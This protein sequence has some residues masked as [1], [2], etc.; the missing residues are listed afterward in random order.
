MGTATGIQERS[1]AQQCSSWRQQ[2]PSHR[3]GS[4]HGA[5]VYRL[6]KQQ[7]AVS[8]MDTQEAHS[9]EHELGQVNEVA[10]VMPWQS[11]SC[12]CSPGFFLRR[13]DVVH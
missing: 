1:T 3:C 13:G 5:G 10:H 6:H 11:A 4:R 2:H 8:T 12:R 9:Q 7:T